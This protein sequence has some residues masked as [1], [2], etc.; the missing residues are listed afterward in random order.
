MILPLI[1][2]DGRT[3]ILSALIFALCPIFQIRAAEPYPLGVALALTGP[4]AYYSRDG[5][6]AIE[7]AVKE[8]NEGGGLLGKHPIV[9]HIRDTRTKPDTTVRAARELILK[10]KAKCVLGTYS[11]ACAIALKQITRKH[12][13][14]HIAAISNSENITMLDFSPYTFSVVPNSY[15]QANAVALGVARLAKQKDWKTFATIA[16][17]YEWGRSTQS[18]FIKLLGKI[19]PDLKLKKEFWPRLGESRFS[20]YISAIFKEKPDFVYGSLASRDNI[21]WMHEA[22][23]YDLF[24]KFPYPGSLLS[25]SE[26]VSQAETLPRGM[27]GLC[28]APFFA[29]MD[30][31]AMKRFVENFRK[32]HGRYPSDWAVMEYDAVCALKQAVGKAGDIDSEKVVK[33][34]K[35]LT[36]DT[37][38]GRLAFRTVDNQLSCSSYLG[39]VSDDPKYPFPIY[40][41]RME[42]RG[43][44]SWRPE[45]EILAARAK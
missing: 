45:E 25:V 9:I 5:I 40:H 30:I 28:R 42:I 38:R 12:R 27:I 17:D 37:T 18:N 10:L 6:D 20:P 35:G 4:G 39:E 32:M 21:A 14:L 22:R 3:M 23:K 2:I 43:P 11:S 36:I 24:K 33:A 34:M 41:A 31:P 44:E 15:M 26:L 7:L 1:H 16:S 19:A 29:H 8:I 13:V